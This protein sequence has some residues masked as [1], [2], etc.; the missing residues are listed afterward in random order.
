MWK[1]ARNHWDICS[2]ADSVTRM[3][4]RNWNFVWANSSL[5]RSF[6]HFQGTFVRRVLSKN[7]V[8]MDVASIEFV[9]T[10]AKQIMKYGLL[11]CQRPSGEF[12]AITPILKYEIGKL[13]SVYPLPCLLWLSLAQETSLRSKKTV[14]ST[15][16]YRKIKRF[17]SFV[18]VSVTSLLIRPKCQSSPE[19]SFDWLIRQLKVLER[20]LGWKIDH[21]NRTTN[22]RHTETITACSCL[23]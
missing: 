9:T 22:K 19:A 15:P 10:K 23:F 21:K 14:L 5:S 1:K 8:K 18:I 4:G 7:R 16:S 13:H 6:S 12:S 20:P 11:V 3:E 17:L 2:T